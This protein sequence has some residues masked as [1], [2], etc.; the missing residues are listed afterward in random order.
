MRIAGK[1]D[2]GFRRADNQ[3]RYIAGALA[4]GLSFGFVCDGMGGANGGSVASGRLCRT[5][6]ECLFLE[7][8]NKAMIAEKTVLDAIDVACSRIYHQ[9]QTNPSLKGMGT[10][11]SGVTVKDNLCTA[12]NAGDS[13][14]YVLRNGVL[15]QITEDHSVVQQLFKQGAITE[16]EMNTHPQKNLITRAVGVKTDVEVDVSETTLVSGDRIL[17]ASDGLTNF[18]KKEIMAQILASE[19]FYNIP[20]ELINK[21][22]ENNASDNITAIVMEY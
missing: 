20:K 14:V 21:A 10:T 3:D 5:L 18:V 7:N 15:T 2:K 1:T 17:C 9:S 11:V 16:D 4:N 19:D 8:D 13:R 12:Y 6:E 22:L